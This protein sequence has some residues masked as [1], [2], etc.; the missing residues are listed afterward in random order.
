LK[1]R[2]IARLSGTTP[3]RDIEGAAR[4]AYPPAVATALFPGP[5]IPAAVLVPLIERSGGL[6]V[7]LTRR[8][9]HLKD[10]PGQV[11]LPGGRIDA[12]DADARAAALREAH[13]ELG[14]APELV[15]VAGYL[16]P[17]AVVTGFAVLPIVGFLPACLELRPDPRE[18]ADVFEV[19]LAFLADP[20]NC[21]VGRRTVREIEL[22]VCEYR[23]G[24]HRIWGATA[25]I[26]K[27]LYDQ[28]LRE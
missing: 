27:N 19:P 1:A 22:P 4:A 23:F 11:S 18:V 28:V 9:D 20:G 24:E 12:A 5:L 10:H 6:A 3:A 14:I 2:I 26:L 16:A 13:E 25:Q 8:T 21:R 7:L 17:H 15:D